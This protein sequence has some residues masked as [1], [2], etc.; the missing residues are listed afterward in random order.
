MDS[1]A[2]RLT[3]GIG[4]VLACAVAWFIMG[5]LV[6][7]LVAGDYVNSQDRPSGWVQG[8]QRILA[9][10]WLFSPIGAILVVVA[11]WARRRRRGVRGSANSARGAGRPGHRTI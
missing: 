3:R 11:L 2:R 9:G 5:F 6:F 7:G 8:L 1:G 10:A 4:V